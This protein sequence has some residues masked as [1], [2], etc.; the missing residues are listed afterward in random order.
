LSVAFSLRRRSSSA[1]KSAS[2][3]VYNSIGTN[4]GS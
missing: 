2:D 3:I 4:S 1:F